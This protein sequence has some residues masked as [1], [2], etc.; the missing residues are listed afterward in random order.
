MAKVDVTAEIAI[1]A[2]P[3]D[4]AAVMFDPEREKEWMAAVQRV[5][6][7]DPA[8][9]PGAR[10]RHHGRFLGRDLSWLTEVEGVHFPHLLALRIA[11]GPF[12]G[13]V[14]Y[15]IQRSG[16]GSVARVKN[17]GEP[18]SFALLPAALVEGPMR[19]ALQGDLARLK[20][21]VEG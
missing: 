9:A 7:L 5:E 19:S 11:E 18:K 16:G 2:S 1:N 12:L 13:T 8:L 14:R 3:A 15:E 6:V 21:L 4:I 10:V 17:V 20:A